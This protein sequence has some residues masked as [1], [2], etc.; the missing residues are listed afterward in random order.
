MN[1][2]WCETEP[3]DRRARRRLRGR[4]GTGRDK[5]EVEVDGEEV[6]ESSRVLR[7]GLW[8]VRREAQVGKE[9]PSVETN[10]RSG[11]VDMS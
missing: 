3:S 10:H 11:G 5:L 2:W 9:Y 7:R 4:A 8:R 6:E 1:G